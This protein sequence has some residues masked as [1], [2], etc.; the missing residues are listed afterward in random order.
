MYMYAIRTYYYFVCLSYSKMIK[1]IRLYQPYCDNNNIRIFDEPVDEYK[2][3]T[4]HIIGSTYT[5]GGLNP[6]P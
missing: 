3:C 4:R 6:P 5:G 2:L 1:M